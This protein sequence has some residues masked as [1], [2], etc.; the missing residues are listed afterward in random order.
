DEAKRLIDAENAKQA[1]AEDHDDDEGDVDDEDEVAD[2]EDEDEDDDDD[3]D[4]D[5]DEPPGRDKVIAA[6][7]MTSRALKLAPGNDD[8][9]FTHAML[10]IDADRA[11]VPRKVDELLHMMPGCSPSV[12][13]N[14]AV[15]MGKHGH[16]RFADA[17][18]I[19]LSEALPERILAEGGGGMVASFGDV[20]DELFSELGEVVLEHA[21]D[22]M[23]KLIPMLPAEIALLAELAWKAV[24][25]KH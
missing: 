12:R 6:L 24:Q 13:I 18:D 1:E 14:V 8:V 4:D 21:P 23:P 10:L 19:A 5:E 16:P 25:A 11:G 3:D 7:G 2:E 17:V 22:R 15:R 20:A 9:Q